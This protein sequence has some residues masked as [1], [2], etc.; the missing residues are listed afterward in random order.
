MRTMRHI[1]SA[2]LAFAVAATSLP[3]IAQT[4]I[5]TIPIGG[6]ITNGAVNP[7]SNKMYVI[8]DTTLSV[9]DGAS[10]TVVAT[11]Q[12]GSSPASIFAQQG[13]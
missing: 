10:N 4:V 1:S 13:N 8:S 9:I 11:V 2:I 12:L 7:A 6:T 3:A 5:A